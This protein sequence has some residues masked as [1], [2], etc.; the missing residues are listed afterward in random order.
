M[1]YEPAPESNRKAR[2]RPCE[3]LVSP[4]L[5]GVRRTQKR[6]QDPTRDGS[7]HIP[8]KSRLVSIMHSRPYNAPPVVMSGGR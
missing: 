2:V 3:V 6:P 8:S 5:G 4:Q 1:Q 7:A